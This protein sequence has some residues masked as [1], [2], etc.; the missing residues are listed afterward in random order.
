[1]SCDSVITA[2]NPWNLLSA[3]LCSCLFLSLAVM[4]RWEKVIL[5]MALA[6]RYWWYCSLV[7]VKIKHQG[8]MSG[9]IKKSISL[10][11]EN[12]LF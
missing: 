10:K 12:P 1:M 3:E 6:I 11:P 2:L 5:K 4:L 7:K 9:G 8:E